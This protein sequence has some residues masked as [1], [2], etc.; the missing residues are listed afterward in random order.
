MALKKTLL[1][2][3]LIETELRKF[4]NYVDNELK[5]SIDYALFPG[6]RIRGT[7]L[8]AYL[9]AYDSQNQAA[10]LA[11]AA[12]IEVTH[13]F[14]LIHDDMPALDNSEMR[15]NKPSFFI[16]FGEANAL[17][18]GD[19]LQYLAQMHLNKFPALQS[20]LIE[21]ACSMVLGQ[22]RESNNP[23]TNLNDLQLTQD[24]KTGK[25]FELVGAMA[26][27]ILNLDNKQAKQVIASCLAYGR[28][29]QWN[30]DINDINEDCKGTNI[31]H[32]ISLDELQIKIKDNLKI[33]RQHESKAILAWEKN[34]AI[35]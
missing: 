31:L 19:L 35:I 27:N 1:S 10:G 12:A 26:A 14:S 15:R 32:F 22:I 9:E 24:L 6:K 34:I 28:H 5:S 21:H 16:K 18:I 17:L 25:L 4:Y 3:L 23:A 7:L 13:A 33:A 29:L 2:K 20:L 8:M 11:A 30:D